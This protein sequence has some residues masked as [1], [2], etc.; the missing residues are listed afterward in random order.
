MAALPKPGRFKIP[1]SRFKI[2]EIV[3]STRNL[4][5]A[6][7]EFHKYQKTLDSGFRRNDEK[8]EIR[9]FYEGINFE[10]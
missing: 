9:A 10:P 7:F 8:R 3:K 5:R 1:N 6:F 4:R 2:D